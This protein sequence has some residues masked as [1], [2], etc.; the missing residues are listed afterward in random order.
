MSNEAIEA[1]KNLT[2]EQVNELNEALESVESPARKQLQEAVKNGDDII[3]VNNS[4]IVDMYKDPNTGI[5]LPISAEEDDDY[6]FLNKSF[7][8][9]IEDESIKVDN[10]EPDKIEITKDNVTNILSPLSENLDT[11]SE[12]DVLQLI[13]LSK[14]YLKG[15]KFSYYN[16]MPDSVKVVIDTIM[17]VKGTEMG[18]MNREGR[19]FIASSLLKEISNDAILGQTIVDFNKTM[20]QTTQNMQDKIKSDEYWYNVRNFFLTTADEKIAYYKEKGEEVIA[21]RYSRA[22]NAF[23][24]SYTYADLKEVYRTGKLK[25]KKIEIEK[26]ERTCKDFNFGYSKSQ[27]VIRDISQIVPVIAAQ[28]DSDIT[29][30]TIKRF[31]VTFIKYTRFKHMNPNDFFNHTYMYFFIYNILTI[32]NYNKDNEDDVKFHFDF[33]KNL[34]DFVHE[35]QNNTK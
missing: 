1:M 16:S 21:E 20:K 7:E 24:E 34:N 8:E 31:V 4:E 6:N 5:N 26:F 29:P 33:L 19:N 32:A 23:I 25:I 18:S 14:R 17:G 3:V 15:E 30:D 13:E 28:V 27:N 10:I 9:I 12:E 11:L 22:K 2:D 35:I